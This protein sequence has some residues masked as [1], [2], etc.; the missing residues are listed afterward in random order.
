MT[1][2]KQIM[3]LIRGERNIDTLAYDDHNLSCWCYQA[4]MSYNKR[5]MVVLGFLGN[6]IRLMLLQFLR[7][8]LIFVFI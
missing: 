4:M 6:T 7:G 1:E 8:K 2:A 5:I 3:A